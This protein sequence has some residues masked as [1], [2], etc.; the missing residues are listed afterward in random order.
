MKKGFAEG[1]IRVGLASYITEI[2][3]PITTRGGGERLGLRGREEVH[4]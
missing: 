3:T 4:V 2:L 1:L